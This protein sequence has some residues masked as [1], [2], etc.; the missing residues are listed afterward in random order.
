[1]EQGRSHLYFLFDLPKRKSH[2]AKTIL[3]E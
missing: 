2:P 3:L 1:V